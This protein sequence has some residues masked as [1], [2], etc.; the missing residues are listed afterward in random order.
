M[1]RFNFIKKTKEKYWMLIFHCFILIIISQ[2]TRKQR[3]IQSLN[4]G[5][6]WTT[7]YKQKYH[8]KN[9]S[10]QGRILLSHRLVGFRSFYKKNFIIPVVLKQV[11][12]ISV[13]LI[14]FRAGQ[15]F[16]GLHRPKEE[17]SGSQPELWRPWCT[18]GRPIYWAHQ[19][20]KGMKHR[21]KWSSLY[22]T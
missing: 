4:Q 20:V 6:N 22:K 9:I 17:R 1:L 18:G 13:L 15:H 12:W 5:W 7:T 19:P 16:F 21:M 14:L 10:W 3:K 8:W 11:K 2:N